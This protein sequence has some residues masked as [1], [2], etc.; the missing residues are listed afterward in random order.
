MSQKLENP[1]G[2]K[3]AAQRQTNRINLLNTHKQLEALKLIIVDHINLLIVL[4]HNLN[5]FS[6]T[7]NEHGTKVYELKE[8]SHSA[9]A[10][11]ELEEDLG[12]VQ[13][14]V[15]QDERVEDHLHSVD[16]AGLVEEQILLIE[17]MK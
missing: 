10:Q 15:E 13:D 9:D 4:E 8:V 16:V 5:I 1:E 14:A 7:N 2:V 12:K 11:L 17:T 3:E 6:D